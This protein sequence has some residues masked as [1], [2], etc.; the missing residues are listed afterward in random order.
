[1]PE[2]LGALVSFSSV[3]FR[4]GAEVG[5]R[6]QQ[7]W[8]L[9][10]RTGTRDI[11]GRYSWLPQMGRQS[12]SHFSSWPPFKFNSPAR[13]RGRHV[14]RAKKMPLGYAA[15]KVWARQ[16]RR[17]KAQVGWRRNGCKVSLTSYWLWNKCRI[18]PL[19][20]LISL[21]SR[22]AEAA[23]LFITG[24]ADHQQSATG[25]S[26]SQSGQTRAGRRSRESSRGASELQLP[27]TLHWLAEPGAGHAPSGWPA[28]AAAAAA[29]ELLKMQIG[30]QVDARPGGEQLIGPSVAQL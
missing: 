11:A 13:A 23:N 8:W 17:A 20:H 14:S 15:P 22:P 27:A 19:G 29:F 25:G 26:I 3:P 24:A 16:S 12:G 30:R 7:E 4:C 10:Y 18:T 21:Q 9:E 28:A 5:S 2:S 6:V 1:M